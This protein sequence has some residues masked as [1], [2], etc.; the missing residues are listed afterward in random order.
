MELK[1]SYLC[2]CGRRRY[3]AQGAA[4][5]RVGGGWRMGQDADLEAGGNDTSLLSNDQLRQQQ[6]TLLR[7]TIWNSFESEGIH[8]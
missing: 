5:E 1:Q 8:K 2:V 3:Q 4:Q 7:G 6:Q